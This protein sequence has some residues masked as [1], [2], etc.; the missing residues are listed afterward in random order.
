MMDDLISR[1][2]ALEEIQGFYPPKVANETEAEA[3]NRVGWECAINCIEAYL[4]TVKP[5][6][7]VKHGKWIKITERPMTTDER[8]KMS[9]ELGYDV[10]YEDDESIVY[11]S[12]LPDENEP[13]LVTREF[14]CGKRKKRYVEIA[15]R[16]GNSWFSYSDE[17]K[18]GNHGRPIA[19]MPLPEP[20]KSRR[21]EE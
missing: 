17:Y 3:I 1:Q 4:R 9:E 18:V 21:S 12:A 13:V 16:I 8:T 15:D 20:Y 7:P 6:D 5:V 10:E 11:T 19:W 14:S 2:A